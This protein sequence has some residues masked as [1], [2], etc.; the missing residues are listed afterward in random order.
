MHVRPRPCLQRPIKFISVVTVT[1]PSVYQTLLDGVDFLNFDL[2]WIVSAGCFLE[3]DFHDGLLSTTVTPVVV[4]GLLDGTCAFAIH[5]NRDAPEA[6]LGNIRKRH[7]SIALLVTF[8]VYSSFS[9][10]VFQTFACEGLDDGKSYLRADY[11]IVCDSPK[12]KA[13]QIYAG[14]VV[15][16]YPIGIPALYA[17]LLFS[18][19]HVLRDEQDRGES[20][21][22]R[23]TSDLWKPY[24]PHRFYYEVIECGRRILLVGVVVFIYPNT[25]AQIAVTLA[26][27]TVFIFVSEAMAPYHSQ[28]DAWISRSG[29]VI[30]FLTIYIALLLKVD[31]S[32]ENS[33]SQKTFEVVIVAGHGCMILAVVV[34]AVIMALLLKGVR[35]RENPSPRFRG[36]SNNPCIIQASLVE[37][38]TGCK[39]EL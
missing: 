28:W 37:E 33:S 7:R 20:A 35:Q 19:H 14:L 3:I 9:S 29:H 11:T 15:M 5:R 17:V 22:A 32:G 6:T 13:F 2:T 25:A 38:D 34:E 27:A 23:L 39:T 18:N 36:S 10:E 31:M 30:V 8:L 4:M 24:K 12:H 1:F 16:M 21:V 26:I